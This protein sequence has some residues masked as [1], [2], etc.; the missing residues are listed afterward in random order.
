MHSC[1]SLISITL[2]IPFF[3]G[4]FCL[5]VSC[6]LFHN[7][8]SVRPRLVTTEKIVWVNAEYYYYSQYQFKYQRNIY[9][10]S[11]SFKIPGIPSGRCSSD[12]GIPEINL[13]SPNNWVGAVPL[14]PDEPVD[15]SN[16]SKVKGSTGS[17]GLYQIS[18][19]LFYLTIYRV[20]AEF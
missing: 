13:T 1:L 9:M 20:S 2:G 6:S 16:C 19:Q 11:Q 17:R 7:S 3:H 5:L 12:F 4:R 14:R 15:C 8:D 10:G 18:I